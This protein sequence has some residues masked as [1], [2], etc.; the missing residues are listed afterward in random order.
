MIIIMTRHSPGARLRSF[1]NS[2]AIKLSRPSAT[3][4]RGPALMG[5]YT[6]V[7]R[8][9]TLRSAT[10]APWFAMSFSSIQWSR[11]TQKIVGKRNWISGLSGQLRHP[12]RSFNVVV[13]IMRRR[14]RMLI[15]ECRCFLYFGSATKPRPSSK[16]MYCQNNFFCFVC[17]VGKREEWEGRVLNV[18][19]SQQG[20]LRTIYV[21]YRCNIY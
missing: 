5:R 2:S 1:R 6:V 12:V 9:T 15:K 18:S 11:R 3:D 19:D 21:Y 13:V 14:Q 8:R 10:T 4:S 17:L 20:R 7:T 16:I